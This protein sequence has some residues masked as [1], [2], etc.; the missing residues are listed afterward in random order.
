MIEVF[1]DGKCSLCSKEINYFKKRHP[2]HPMVWH[3][4]ANNPQR[5]EGTGLSQSEALMFMRVKDAHGRIRSG[6]DA[7]IVL[8]GQFPG[9]HLLSRFAALPGIHFIADKLYQQF[10][11]YRFVNH[12]HCQASLDK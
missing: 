4:I 6:V 2:K 12:T 1:Y 10:A 9:W 3:D 8:W 5:L 11:R 7:F